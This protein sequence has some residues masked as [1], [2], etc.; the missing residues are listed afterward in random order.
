MRSAHACFNSMLEI[1]CDA[2]VRDNA[3]LAFDS[4]RYG[5]NNSR[6]ATHCDVPFSW[7]CD[8]DVQFLLNRACAGRRRCSIDV[9]VD[10]FTDPCGYAEFLTVV[11]RCVPGLFCLVL[12][13]ARNFNVKPRIGVG[14]GGTGGHLSPQNSGKYFSGK[15]HVKFGQFV[16]FSYI[17]FRAEMY[18]PKVDCSAD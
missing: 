16:N 6:V 10:R 18:C 4:A 1:S 11:Y 7:N 5:R 8:I 15:Y 17:Y 2:T 3:L 12:G 13:R 14:D 9:G